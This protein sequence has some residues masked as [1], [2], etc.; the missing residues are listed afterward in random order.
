MNLMSD[1]KVLVFGA[2]CWIGKRFVKKVNE[3]SGYIK[4]IP[5]NTEIRTLEDVRDEMDRVKPDAVLNAVSPPSNH[6]DIIWDSNVRVPMII[7]DVCQERGCSF[8]H[9]S[10]GRIFNQ[11]KISPLF[12][13]D[14]ED[15]PNPADHHLKTVFEGEQLLLNEESLILRLG[16]PFDDSSNENSLIVKLIEALKSGRSFSD[17][18]VSVI[19]VDDLIW[20]TLRLIETRM[21][22]IYHIANPTA[23]S[24]KLITNRIKELGIVDLAPGNFSSTQDELNSGCVLDIM[25]LEKE[26]KI[27]GRPIQFS[28]QALERYLRRYKSYLL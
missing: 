3:T 8:T 17:D 14:E 10:T 11:N 23:V 12:G 21:T 4:A 5:G 20:I 24:F 1:F 22:G 15:I 27:I 18:E 25:K 9:F 6:P 19:C 13:F 26:L 2:D 28:W 7:S 16:T